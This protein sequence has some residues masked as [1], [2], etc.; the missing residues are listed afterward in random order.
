[1]SRFSTGKTKHERYLAKL[2]MKRMIEEEHKSLKQIGEHFGISKQAVSLNL[3]SIGYFPR[4]EIK[5]KRY[6]NKQNT[7]YESLVE[8]IEDKNLKIASLK[9]QIIYRDKKIKELEEK[10]G[11]VNELFCNN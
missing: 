7:T 9:Q 2:E 1:M 4:H 5:N 3:I 8:I 11:K 6:R 10:I